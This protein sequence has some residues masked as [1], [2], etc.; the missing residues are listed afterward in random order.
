MEWAQRG[1]APHNITILTTIENQDADWRIPHLLRIPAAR[2]GLSLEPLLGPV[3][4]SNYTPWLAE[5]KWGGI[6]WLIIGGESGS[7]ARPCNVEW[8]RSLVRQ[9]QSA[10]VPVFVKQLGANVRTD[11][12][13]PDGWPVGT[14]LDGHTPSALAR[15]RLRSPK[16]ADP[17]EWRE[18]LR[19]QQWP[20]TI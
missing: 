8:I 10:G 20:E 7:K 1:K 13:T 18:D 17:S 16:G 2:R 12:F 15:V 19:V 4:L 9:G 5:S 3:D 14:Y 6:S 11:E